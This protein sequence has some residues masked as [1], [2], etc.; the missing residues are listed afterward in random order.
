MNKQGEFL[1]VAL[2][3]ASIDRGEKEKN[4]A[5]LLEL[6]EEAAGAEARVI[7]NTELAASGYS[8]AGR[9]KIGP[10]VRTISGPA[11]RAFGRIAKRYGCY[12]CIDL[13]EVERRTGVFYNAAAGLPGKPVGRQEQPAGTGGAD[14]IRRAGR[15]DLCR[16]QR[17]PPAA[18]GNPV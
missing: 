6:N 2:A 13:P 14:G 10:L 16:R 3:H 8:F 7:V 4:L 9:E 17:H 5:R 15:G 11:T 12:I 18:G 1:K